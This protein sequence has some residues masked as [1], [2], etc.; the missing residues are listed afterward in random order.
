MDV[1]VLLTG[2]VPFGGDADN[3]S[4]A[5]A[6]ALDRQTIEAHVG[7]RAVL[8][9]IFSAY[10]VPVVFHDESNPTSTSTGA[11]RVAHEIEARQPDVVISMG[12]APGD[13]FRV[14]RVAHNIIQRGLTDNTGRPY[15][16]LDGA[17]ATPDGDGFY[18]HGD[19]LV[20][21]RTHLPVEACE[22]AI[23]GEHGRTVAS[24]DPGEYVCEDVMFEVLREIDAPRSG[25]RIL[26][27][28]FIHVPRDAPQDLVNR[29]IFAAVRAT[30]ASLTEAELSG[31]PVA[32]RLAPSF[33][34]GA[35]P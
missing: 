6:R 27:G 33:E 2:F 13:A 35:R 32:A 20:T 30:I 18:H 19:A 3:P 29:C 9:T 10:D 1:K 28:G 23:Q 22:A 14:E 34:P 15:A 31:D 16:P 21:L 8:A 12:V 7:A 4:G 17:R 26:R 5:C 24:D 25:H 11:G